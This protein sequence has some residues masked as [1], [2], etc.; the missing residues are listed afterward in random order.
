VRGRAVAVDLA[1]GPSRNT[2]SLH[3]DLQWHSL[4]SSFAESGPPS[5]PYFIKEKTSTFS[6]SRF[7]RCQENK[8]LKIPEDS[9]S[10]KKI[11]KN[12]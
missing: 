9:I 11:P 8:F 6:K 2:N 1:G 7:A 12:S 3:P 4:L 5:P 10:G